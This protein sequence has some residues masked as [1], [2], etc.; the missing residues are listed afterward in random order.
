VIGR[1]AQGIGA[2]VAGRASASNRRRCSGMIEGAGRPTDRRIVA[3]IALSRGRNMGRGLHLRILGNES[4]AMT[5]RAR[6]LQA[7]M[8]HHRRR[9]G[10]KS[11]GVAGI[12][13]GNGRNMVDR[14]GQRIGVYMTA[15]M[16]AGTLAGR[17]RMTHPRR[18]EGREAGMTGVALRAGG[19]VVG[20]LP[21]RR[22]TV[23]TGGALAIGAGIVRVNSRCPGDCGGVAGIALSAGADVRHRLHLGILGQIG[24]AVAGRTQPGQSAVVHGSRTPVDETADVAVI[25]LGNAGNVIDRAR[26]RIGEKI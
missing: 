3:S 19:D 10:H 18:P 4:T 26:Q 11:S 24:A 14:L 2:V 13:L 1:L 22:C 20:R 12:A 8:T 17:T 5:V 25:A 9:P 21:Q 7:R 23:V 6:T 15:A 16:A